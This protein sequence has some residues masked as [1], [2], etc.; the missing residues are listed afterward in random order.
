M[1][2]LVLNRSLARTAL[3]AAVSTARALPRTTPVL[4]V[5]MATSALKQ[6][7]RAVVPGGPS[8]FAAGSSIKAAIAPARAT[9]RVPANDW[10]KAG[11]AQA[12]K[13]C[14][15]TPAAKG[16]MMAKMGAL[17]ASWPISTAVFTTCARTAPCD[18]WAQ[19][20]GEGKEEID[21]RRFWGFMIF[22]AVYVGVF[23]YY[24]YSM[25]LNGANF[26]ALTGLNGTAAVAFGLA[27][28]DQFVHSPLLYFPAF[29]FTM[30]MVEGVE[31]SQVI[32]ETFAKWQRDVLGVMYASCFLWLPAQIVNFYFMPVYLRVPYINTIGAVWVVWLSLNEGKSKAAE[33]GVTEA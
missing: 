16:G 32:P 21:W 30:K 8:T 10:V 19:V 6:G 2:S 31:L 18:L 1:S 5:P 4:P 20:Y 28:V 27:L 3:Q 26:T 11:L 15:A 23:Q 7:F 9:V 13:M 12:R 25:V 14:T 33:K 24:L 17:L 22:G 29:C